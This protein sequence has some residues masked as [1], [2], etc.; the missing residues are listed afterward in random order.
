MLH[1]LAQDVGVANFARPLVQFVNALPKLGSNAGERPEIVERGAQTREL[2]AR[3]MQPFRRPR[4]FAI[5]GKGL[6]PLA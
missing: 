4:L 6:D 2:L 1:A 5:G 3:A